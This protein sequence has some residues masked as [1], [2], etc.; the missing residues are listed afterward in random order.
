M[1]VNIFTAADYVDSST[2]KLVIVGAFDNIETDECP[3]SFKPFGVAIKLILEPRDMGKTYEGQ[4]ILRKDKT[5]KP[6]FDLRTS[7]KIMTKHGKKISSIILGLNIVGTRFDTFGTYILEFKI[8][9]RIISSTKIN[10]VK[11]SQSGQPKK[12]KVKTKNLEVNCSNNTSERIR[13]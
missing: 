8:D 5:V 1:K 2:G 12:A 6:M 9:S 4:L 13:G 7:Q 3:F 10:V 11:K